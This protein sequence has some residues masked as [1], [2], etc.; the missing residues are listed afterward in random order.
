[1]EQ[2]SALGTGLKITAKTRIGASKIICEI[3]DR[4]RIEEQFISSHAFHRTPD[5]HIQKIIA[6]ERFESRILESFDPVT[7]ELY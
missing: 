1:M 4:N 7:Q 5:G 2:L 3:D 6:E